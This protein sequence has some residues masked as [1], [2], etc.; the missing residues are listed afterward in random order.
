MR[1][2]TG[3]AAAKRHEHH[4]KERDVVFVDPLD[5]HEKYWW[6]AIIVPEDEI[7][8][9][10]GVLELKSG[11]CL[12]KYF[13]DDKY[14]VVQFKDLRPFLPD[15]E[16]YRSF[17]TRSSAFA[18]SRGVR[19]AIEYLKTGKPSKSFAWPLWGTSTASTDD[20]SNGSPASPIDEDYTMGEDLFNEFPVRRRT[21]RSRAAKQ[22]QANGDEAEFVELTQFRGR[23]EAVVQARKMSSSSESSLTE[24]PSGT[25]NT[26]EQNVSDEFPHP[27]AARSERRGSKRRRSNRQSSGSVPDLNDKTA[28]SLTS[29]DLRLSPSPIPSEESVGSVSKRRRSE[30]ANSSNRRASRPGDYGEDFETGEEETT[31]EVKEP[32]S[33]LDKDKE[34]W[35][36]RRS[37][38]SR[39][40]SNKLA[41]S[42]GDAM[43]GRQPSTNEKESS[44]AINAEGPTPTPTSMET[45]DDRDYEVSSGSKSNK[46]L[47]E[48]A[49]LDA[50]AEVQDF[51]FPS[52]EELFAM[53]KT[54]REE[55][56]RAAWDHL[57]LIR[58]DYRRI[59][60]M[61]GRW[62]GETRK[63]RWNEETAVMTRGSKRKKR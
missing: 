29:K 21:T 9:S 41:V 12:V 18:K 49:A 57:M 3:A 27:S 54:K 37:S 23:V 42:V 22:S 13:E 14:S 4:F 20:N 39:G 50:E 24:K 38:R 15:S 51:A 2:A 53:P 19:K 34:E 55:L 25:S 7:D 6:P 44:A 46:I 61:M 40:G 52:E 28:T 8:Q 63:K 59:E 47:E 60:K 26:L 48:F 32:S 5:E 36:S 45:P 16:P 56:Y 43:K 58:A 33:V 17:A 35:G 10:M 30:G 31:S 62:K 1:S 11:E